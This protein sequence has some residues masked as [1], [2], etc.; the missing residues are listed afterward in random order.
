MN[1]QI[2]VFQNEEFGK[3]EVLMIGG[4][5]HFPATECAKIL[6]YKNTKDAILRHCKGVVKHDLPSASGIQ[7]YNFIPEGDLYR[8]II[9]SKLPAAVCF[10]AWVLCA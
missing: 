9:R 5:P 1:N 3:I 8:L 2:Q 4:K 6:G 10:E 7:S